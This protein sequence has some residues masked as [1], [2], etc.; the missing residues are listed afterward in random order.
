MHQ[1]F[2]LISLRLISKI[3]S[4][5]GARYIIHIDQVTNFK[6]K[7]VTELCKLYDIKKTRTTS[8]HPQ[9]YGLVERLNR[10][11]VDTYALIA[12]DAQDTWD[13]S[14]KLALMAIW[15]AA[16]S[17]TGYSPHFLLFGRKMRL[18]DDLYY[19]L[20]PEESSSAIQSL[21]N[22]RQVLA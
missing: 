15:L 4:R 20:P 6:S 7:L 17:T 18:P 13:L 5:Y 3:I 1:D 11:L 8:Y 22:L 10:K 16:Q 21:A 9:S 14:I 12:K 19:N 2:Y